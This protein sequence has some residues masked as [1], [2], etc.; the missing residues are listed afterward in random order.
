VGR[1]LEPVGETDE[2]RL[3]PSLLQLVEWLPFLDEDCR[4]KHRAEGMSGALVAG[5]DA[6]NHA[7]VDIVDRT[8]DDWIS[9]FDESGHLGSHPGEDGIELTSGEFDDL[10]LDCGTPWEDALYGCEDLVGIPGHADHDQ[11]PALWVKAEGCEPGICM[12][13]L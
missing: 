10:E 7:I 13:C 6:D 8:A 5:V 12:E 9:L 4:A 3:G 2:G 11:I 1:L